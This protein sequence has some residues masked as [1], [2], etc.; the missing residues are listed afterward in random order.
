MNNGNKV[1]QVS[2]GMPVY[3]GEPYIREA[4]DSLLAQTFTDFELIISDNASRDYTE[5]ICKEYEAKDA[6]IRYVRQAENIGAAANFQIVLSEAVG[7]HFMWA[8][9]DDFWGETWIESLL[10]TRSRNDASIVGQIVFVRDGEGVQKYLPDFTKGRV[11]SFFLSRKNKAMYIYGLFDTAQLKNESYIIQKCRSR[12]ADHVFLTIIL[13]NGGFRQIDS[14]TMYYRIHKDQCSNFI[15]HRTAKTLIKEALSLYLFPYYRD[16]INF[17]PIR[18]A[19]IL[20]IVMP[21][22]YVKISILSCFRVVRRLF[23]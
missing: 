15:K 9:A 3:N 12:A 8:A 10:A 5:A 23:G 18:F 22:H 6:R 7:K 16:L 17:L 4:L 13:Q 21:I 1:P 14:G 19:I 20:V 2:I 11:V